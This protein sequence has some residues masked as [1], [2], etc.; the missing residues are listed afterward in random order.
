[1]PE[2]P[3]VE[4]TRRGLEPLLVGQTFTDVDVRQPSLRWP[5]ESLLAERIR[6]RCVR[7]V[8]R[9]GKYL[10]VTTD[11]G[12][13][14]IHLGMSGNL[15]F[16]HEPTAPSQHDHV[17]FF[18]ASGAQLRFNDP[19]RFGSVHFTTSPTDHWLLKNLG[20]EP[21]SNQFN[22]NYLWKVSRQR[23]VAI[24]QFLMN[25]RIVVGVGNIYASEVLFRTGIHPKRS[26]GRIARRHF[27]PLVDS[28]RAV[29]NEAIA[30]GGTTLRNFVSG[31]GRPGYFQQALSVYGR[32]GEP[33]TECATPIKHCVM[34]QRATYYCSQCQH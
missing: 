13:L 19:R 20:P 12:T 10:L 21:L 29:L 11:G 9:R 25:G 26:A 17:D 32:A 33:C 5:V 28:V 34:G 4:T 30:A 27:E 8:A 24:K 2:L 18:F 22:A 23:R 15:R 3:E 7:S 14:L 6:M 1:M 31:D 16:L